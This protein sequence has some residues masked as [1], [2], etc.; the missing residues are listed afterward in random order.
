MAA[1]EKR[2]ISLPSDQASYINFKAKADAY[3]SASEVNRAGSRALKERD[4]AV[5]RRLQMQVA[6]SFDAMLA[7]PARAV[8]VEDAFTGVRARHAGR[9]KEQK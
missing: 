6:S 9:L 4:E 3:A 5:E 8:P 2:A 7:D 1:V